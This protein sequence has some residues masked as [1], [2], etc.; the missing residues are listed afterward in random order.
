MTAGWPI[1]CS[2]SAMASRDANW[3]SAFGIGSP[4]GSCVGY[5]S[6]AS[7]SA[8]S[9]GVTRVF[10]PIRG[11]VDRLERHAQFVGEIALEEAMRADDPHGDLLAAGGE[12]DSRAG[13]P[14]QAPCLHLGDEIEG[15]RDAK[16]QTAGERLRRRQRAAQFGRVQVLERVLDERTVPTFTGTMPARGQSH[17]GQQR[18]DEQRQRR[19]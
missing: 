12:R 10:P 9:S 3:P 19:D 1:G 14:D 2:D 11:G 7:N 13:R 17:A 5:P 4:W 6:R 15:R 8:A 18:Q 16:T